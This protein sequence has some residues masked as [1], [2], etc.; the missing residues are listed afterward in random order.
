M[1][2]KN[3]KEQRR[4]QTSLTRESRKVRGSETYLDL[5]SS[6]KSSMPSFL[7]RVL[8]Q[9]KTKEGR[10]SALSFASNFREEP[11]R[12]ERPILLLL[13][14]ACVPYTSDHGARSEQFFSS[15]LHLAL[16]SLAPGW[17][18]EKTQRPPSSAV[19]PLPPPFAA[20]TDHE[21]LERLDQGTRLTF[22]S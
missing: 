6:M 1:D 18:R 17:L 7:G 15:P 8:N 13:P 16:L 21:Q 5:R 2:R 22:P 11:E 12:G 14:P 9:S 19:S 20:E 4:V 3:G 10:E